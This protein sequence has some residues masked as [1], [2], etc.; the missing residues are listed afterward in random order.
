MEFRKRLAACGILSNFLEFLEGYI[1]K[2][3]TLL[4]RNQGV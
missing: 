3:N 2:W 4:F 1:R